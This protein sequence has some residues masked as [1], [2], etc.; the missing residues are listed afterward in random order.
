MA[1]A[2]DGKERSQN[3]E[4]TDRDAAADFDFDQEHDPERAKKVS[5]MRM[6]RST[7]GAQDSLPH[8]DKIQASFGHHDI[9]SARAVVGGDEADVILAPQARVDDDDGNAAT[10]GVS[11]RADQ[12]GVVERRED[13]ARNAT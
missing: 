13:D 6:R 9:S 10:G 11:H 1:R 8:A 5:A 3:L 12:R 7:D 4:R 2:S